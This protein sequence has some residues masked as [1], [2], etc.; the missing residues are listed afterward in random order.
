MPLVRTY[1]RDVRGTGASQATRA[2]I[3]R[4]ERASLA[5]DRV[6]RSLAQW[7]PRRVPMAEELRSYDEK[8]SALLTP[9]AAAWMAEGRSRLL[10]A[11]NP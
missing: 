9:E 2:F 7:R 3:G 5:A 4:A 8:V 1:V 10:S 6:A 11:A